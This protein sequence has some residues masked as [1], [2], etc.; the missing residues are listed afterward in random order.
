MHKLHKNLDKT[1]VLIDD[2]LNEE[3]NGL[4][5]NCLVEGKCKGKQEKYVFNLS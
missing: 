4:N 2:D 5:K 3:F 1:N